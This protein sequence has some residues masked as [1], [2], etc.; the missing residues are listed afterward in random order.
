MAI[1]LLPV[2]ALADRTI[3]S[4]SPAPSSTSTD[5]TSISTEPP[6]PFEAARVDYDE[7][8]RLLLPGNVKHGGYGAPEVKFTTM[9][10][11]PAIL[12]G[13]QGGWIVN[14]GFVIGFA[15]YGLSTTHDAP[16]PFTVAN[17]RSTLQF[18]YGGPLLSY[19]VRPHDVVHA[20][21][22]LLVGGGG[23]T[24]LSRDV[25]SDE[26]RTHDGRGFFVLEPQAELEANVL[27]FLRVG[28]GVSWRYVG[29][30]DVPYLAT[31]DLS[32]A[33]AGMFVKI[34]SF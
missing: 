3:A 23:Y 6:K 11:E 16:A 33:S 32:G 29:T 27:K 31:N 5:T 30:K 24:I 13:F 20:T 2:S 26:S 4:T 7:P 28:F 14:H 9:T 15:G 1:A 25:V 21:L 19:I 12:V 10:G 22:G 17:A 18:G 8:D 34:G